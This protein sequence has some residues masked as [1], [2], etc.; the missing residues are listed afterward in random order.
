LRYVVLRLTIL[1]IVD[2]IDMPSSCALRG[3]TTTNRVIAT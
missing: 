3:A 2:E 1:G